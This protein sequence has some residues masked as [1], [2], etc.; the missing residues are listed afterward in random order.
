MV[1][2]KQK[3]KRTNKKALLIVG[4]LL[5]LLL[6]AVGVYVYQQ[7][8]VEEPESIVADPNFNDGTDREPGSS[9]ER[10]GGVTPNPDD[11]TAPEGDPIT[12]ESGNISVYEPQQNQVLKSGGRLYGTSKLD[13][14]WYRLIDDK[15]GVVAQGSL[16]VTNGKFSGTFNFTS[17]GTEGRLDIFNMTEDGLETDNIEVNIKLR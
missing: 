7:R 12:S 2:V 9:V 17:D 8:Q 6:G 11:Q 10:D 1:K 13:T 3:N 16:A 14:I 5:A 4:I 15:I